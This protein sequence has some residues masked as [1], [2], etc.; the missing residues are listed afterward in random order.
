M[1]IALETERLILRPL[2]AQDV[3]PHIKMM[4]DER[5]AAYLTID[6]KTRS[7]ADEWRAAASYIG[8]W[9]IRGYGFFSVFE[10]ASGDWLGRVGPWNPGGWIGL[11][12]GWS[13]SADHWGQGYAPEAAIATMKWTFETFQDVDRIVSVIDPTNVNSQRVAEKIGE[14]KTDEIFDYGSFK[15]NVWACQRDQWLS[16]F[17]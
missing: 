15:L 16:A 9:Q 14:T 3:E 5:I 6:G 2:G 7:Y 13:I 12:C 1:S 17:G 4:Q 10:K 8:H 11:E